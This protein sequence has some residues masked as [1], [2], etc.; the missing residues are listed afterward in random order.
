MKLH[1]LRE[2]LFP[3]GCAVCAEA[4]LNAAESFCGIC[5]DCERIFD[6]ALKDERRCL[7]CGKPLISEREA[8]LL[9]RGEDGL[10]RQMYSERIEKIWRIF[11][12]RGKFKDLL[13]AYKFKKH[14]A[15]GNYFRRCFN[16]I[17]E[18]FFPST[19]GQYGNSGAVLVPV[20]PRPG[21]VKKQGW[22]QI[23]FLA[24][25]LKKSGSFPVSR[26][27]KRLPSQS[28]KE[29]NREERGSNLK[30]RILCVKAPPETVIL[31]DDVITTGA[32]IDAC[33]EALLQGGA[34]KVYAICLFFD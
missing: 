34:K 13:G 10:T 25:R 16:F 8:C 18:E 14:T 5:E 1:Y 4:L 9:C 32:T 12:Y 6:A 2:Y 30:G 27:L 17:L 3:S 29:L 23:D 19:E 24:K 28:Q 7:V 31:F 20:P 11:P 26:C 15:V 33:A 22:D 21:K